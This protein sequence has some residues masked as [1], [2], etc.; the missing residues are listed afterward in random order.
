MIDL[1][2]RISERIREDNSRDMGGA[3]TAA[4]K[5]KSGSSGA[6]FRD[7]AIANLPAPLVMQ[8]RLVQHIQK[9]MEVLGRQAHSLAHAAQR[10]AAFA[11]NELYRKIRRLSLLMEEII[12]ASAE[13]IRRFY[14]AVFIDNQPI[15]VSGHVA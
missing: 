7:Q 4:A 15:L 12:R 11:L 10:G 14:I 2:G 9:E 5:A 3:A 1:M 13:L 8:Q 6:T